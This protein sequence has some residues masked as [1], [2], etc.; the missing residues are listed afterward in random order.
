MRPR[1]EGRGERCGVAEM[2]SHGV[3][4][5]MRPRPE[6]RGE[7]LDRLS[8]S[9]GWH[10]FNAA[11]TRRPW[12]TYRCLGGTSTRTTLQCGHDPKAVENSRMLR[13]PRQLTSFNA[14]TTRRP[15]RTPLAVAIGARLPG[16][17]AATTR[18][19]WRTTGRCWHRTVMTA[20]SMRP[21]PEGRGEPCGRGRR[22]WTRPWLQCGHDPKA[23]ENPDAAVHR[24]DV[25]DKLQCGHDP[26]AVE[27]RRAGAGPRRAARASMRPRP[28]GRGERR[29][30]AEPNSCPAMLQC[31]HDPKAVENRQ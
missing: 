20:A 4:A 8:A 25:A 18:R 14:A 12:R 17:N 22:A 9:A 30:G 1:P 23:V 3:V 10:R 6:G 16:F 15:W 27:N 31:G 19:P 11:T 13:R 24:G 2:R 28:E 21:R 7:P 5:S 26:K 29:R